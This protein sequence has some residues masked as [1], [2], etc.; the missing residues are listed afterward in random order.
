MTTPG[1][2]IYQLQEVTPEDAT[3]LK[4][5]FGHLTDTPQAEPCEERLSAIVESPH[6]ALFVARHEGVIVGSLTIAHLSLPTSEKL[7]IE[8]VV[9]S[10]AAR[11]QGLG[12]RLVMAA[13][14]WGRNHYPSAVIYLTSN[15]SRTAARA[16][17]RSL[18]FE[19]YNTGVFK[20][21]NQ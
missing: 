13:Q 18:G 4:A 10:P 5:L 16:L 11:G 8:D 7:W 20:F 1:T 15:P 12:R 3:Q 21:N 19:E 17:Y 9:V 14:E 6:A 2:I